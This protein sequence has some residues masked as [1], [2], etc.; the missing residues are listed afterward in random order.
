VRAR[1]RGAPPADGQRHGRSQVLQRL[2]R[3]FGPSHLHQAQDRV[4]DHDRDDGGGLDIVAEER[5][6]HGR[7]NQDDHDKVVELGDQPLS[8]GRARR[9][10]ELVVAVL[11]PAALYLVRLKAVLRRRAEALT[12]RL[13]AHGMPV[14]P[15][16]ILRWRGGCHPSGLG[17]CWIGH[18][19][20]L[21][22]CGRRR[23]GPGDIP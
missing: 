17:T 5:R 11:E 14:D 15:V 2:Q 8:K 20:I 7:D 12:H 22:A 13:L 9:R 18:G 4:E 16:P 6:E 23:T 10:G 19:S 1:A 21:A 3:R